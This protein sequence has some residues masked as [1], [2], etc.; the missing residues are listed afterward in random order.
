MS[1][2]ADAAFLIVIIHLDGGPRLCVLHK[3]KTKSEPLGASN[4]GKVALFVDIT[5]HRLASSEGGA[6][7]KT[8]VVIVARDTKRKTRNDLNV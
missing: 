6:S 5:L 1:K 2:R 4:C 7:K 8:T 3:H